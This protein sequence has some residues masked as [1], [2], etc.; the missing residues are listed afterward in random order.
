MSVV[1]WGVRMRQVRQLPLAPFQTNLIYGILA[2]QIFVDLDKK[3][4]KPSLQQILLI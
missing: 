3:G 4:R 2:L 1:S